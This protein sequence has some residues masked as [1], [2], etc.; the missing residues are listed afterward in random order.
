LLA[1]LI[2]LQKKAD[3]K[4]AISLF[5]RYFPNSFFIRSLCSPNFGT[6]PVMTAS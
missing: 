4:F 1:K 2:A 6:V 3:G 5:L